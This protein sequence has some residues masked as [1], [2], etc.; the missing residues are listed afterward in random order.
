MPLLTAQQTNLP[1]YSPQRL[2][3]AERQAG[4]LRVPI[5]KLLV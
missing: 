3:D 2:F 5:L 4:K 1:S